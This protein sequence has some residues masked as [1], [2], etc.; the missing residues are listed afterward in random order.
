[1]ATCPCFAPHPSG[2]CTLL[3]PHTRPRPPPHFSTRTSNPFTSPYRIAQGVT[4]PL[5]GQ[6]FF[7]A[8]LFSAFGSSKRW[9]ATNAD[10]SPRELQWIDFYKVRVTLVV[11]VVPGAVRSAAPRV[12]YY[13]LRRA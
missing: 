3:A 8:S 2:S 13:P 11:V 1:M 10:G 7:R 5:M 4:S 12:S 9:L 6:M